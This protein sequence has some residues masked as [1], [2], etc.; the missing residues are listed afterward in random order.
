MGTLVAE[1]LASDPR[2]AEGKRLLLEALA[3]HRSRLLGIRPADPER[4]AEYAE[5][6]RGFGALRAGPLYFPYLGGGLGRG[7]LVELADGSVKY[8]FISGIGVHHWGHSHLGLA[9]ACI[10]GALRDTVMQGNLE[11][12]A[13]SAEVARLFLEAANRR[14]AALAH[15]F[16]TT[17]GAMANENA[18]K[19]AFQKGSPAQR[20]LAF[21]GGFAGR[22][23]ALSQVTDKPDYRSGLPS[24]LAVDYVP[25]FDPERPAESTEAAVAVLRG[26]LRRYP[27]QHAAMIFEFVQGEGGFRVGHRDFFEP[28]MSAVR[29]AGAVVVADEIQTFGRTS[30]PFAFQHF[31][32]DAHVD[33]VTVGKMTQVC[34][35]LFRGELR[36]RPGLLSQTFTAST[37]ALAA[38]RWVLKELASGGY[39]GPE[40]K[41]LRLHARFE[42]RLRALARARPARL[43]GPFGIGAMVAF[44]PL[45]GDKARVEGFVQALF[46]AGV[47]GFTAGHDPTR[48]RFLVP[49][50]AVDVDDVDRV[51]DI[52]EKTLAELDG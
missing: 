26:H 36:P 48:V 3:E 46:Q 13:E 32:L 5:R 38:A 25:Y 33:I 49:A 11:Q 23:L 34:A 41:N 39:F 44:T 29:E 15:C 7:A 4:E 47:I 43:Q 31:G 18:L 28:L 22:T 2:M 16:L 14:G 21:E 12:N 52:V 51:M 30:E 40:G 19:I 35:T 10:E 17:S 6:I 8:D 50:G 45:G 42:S 27:G 24:T 9:D 1:D 20:I 37:S